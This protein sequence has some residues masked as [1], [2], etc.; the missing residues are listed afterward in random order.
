MVSTFRYSSTETNPIEIPVDSAVVIEIGDLVYMATD[1]VRNAGAQADQTGEEANQA[2]FAGNF[3]GVALV[4]SADG[5]TKDIL[6]ATTGVFRFATP[7]A[8]YEIGDLVGASEESGGTALEDQQVESV[9]RPE[10]AIGLVEKATSSATSVDVRILSTVF[11]T[12]IDHKKYYT[13]AAMSDAAVT[14]VADDAY[15]QTMIP[16]TP[17]NIELPLEAVS[18]GLTFQVRNKAATTIAI[19]VRGAGPVTI[20]SPTKDETAYVW[21]DGTTWYGMV[22]SNI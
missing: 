10:N 2:L 1:D 4:G 6:V 22:G 17:R 7:S 3:L 13:T 15:N 8:S 14:L 9:L 5:E 12:Q 19:N 18:T 16:T 21:C 20:A 11:G